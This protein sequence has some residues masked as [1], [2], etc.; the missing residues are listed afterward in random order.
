MISLQAATGAAPIDVV[1]VEL[2]A[3]IT[4]LALLARLAARAGIS[5]IPLYLLGGLAFGRGGL[6]PLDSADEV[7]RVGSEIGA[8]LLLFML[9]LEYTGAQLARGVRSH[10]KSGLIDLA[11]N[12]PVGVAAGRIAGWPWSASFLMGGVT[13]VTSSGIV[14]KILTDL[15]WSAKPETPAVI[16]MLVLEDL[17]L[18]FLLPLLAIA[19]DGAEVATLTTVVTSVVAVFVALALALKAGGRLSAILAHRSA[20]VM[21]LTMF[22][23][24]L[25][26]A[27]GSHRVGIAAAVGAFLLGLALTGSVADQTHHLLA[28]LRD[29]FAALFFFFFALQLDPHELVPVLVPALLLAL[30]SGA[31][32]VAT[33]WWAAAR[34]TRDTRARW[35]AGLLLIPRGEFSIVIAGLAVALPEVGRFAAAY[36]LMTAIG[37]PLAIRLLS[38]RL[39]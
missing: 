2:G 36:V 7:L 15:R 25:L 16:S 35:R 14:S 19:A 17:A 12:A 24:V 37:G 38:K 9:G 18:A 34:E 29:L 8:V 32:K 1:L 13:Y 30:A 31:T 22:G 3:A 5:P 33:G 28:P 23:A 6:A 10:F 27:G 21:L 4:G 11:L 39:S 26:V 20:E